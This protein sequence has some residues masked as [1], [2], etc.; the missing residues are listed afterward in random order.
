MWR[1]GKLAT[2]AKEGLKQKGP[3]MLDHAAKRG[4]RR[5]TETRR[6]GKEGCE[7]KKRDKAWQKKSCE[8]EKRDKA[9]QNEGCEGEIESRRRSK[10]EKSVEKPPK[11]HFKTTFVNNL[12][13]NY[14]L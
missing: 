3:K 1:K 2:M 8:S 14:Y 9:R 7:G 12:L 13:Q 11:N 6:C 5:G 4:L 10:V